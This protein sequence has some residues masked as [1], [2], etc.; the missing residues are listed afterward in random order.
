VWLSV[1]NAGSDAI[2]AL[3]ID[4]KAQIEALV[5]DPEESLLILRM[6]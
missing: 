5:G 6:P 4:G 2:R 1:G 3:L